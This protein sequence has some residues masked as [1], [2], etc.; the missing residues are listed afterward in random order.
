[1][2]WSSN[3]RHE[4]NWI[5]GAPLPTLTHPPEGKDASHLKVWHCGY[6]R[7]E[8][9]NLLAHQLLLLHTIHA[10]SEDCFA[11]T[12]GVRKRAQ[13][14]SKRQTLQLMVTA[15]QAFS[16]KNNTHMIT[17]TITETKC[18]Y[19]A[20]KFHCKWMTL[21]CLVYIRHHSLQKPSNTYC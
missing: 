20:C 5:G 4:C 19:H 9:D 14:P 10:L 13:Q 1:M 12:P 17:H 3:A 11:C 15:M 2:P 21:E 18:N 16:L 6:C 7:F 8:E